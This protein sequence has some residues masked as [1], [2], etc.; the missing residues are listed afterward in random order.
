MPYR[1]L[2][3]TD[4][5]RF[6]ALNQAYQKGKELPPFK[7]AFSQSTFQKVISFLPTFEKM[8]SRQKEAFNNQIK[9][10]S[11]FHEQMKK[12]KLYISHFI[13]VVNMA[14]QRGEL[15]TSIREYYQLNQYGAKLPPLNTE[16]EVILLGNNMIEGEA[17]RIREGL[18]PI[19]N[20]TIAV[21]KVRYDNFIEAY[22]DKKNLQIT[23][24]KAFKDL[25]D[26]R[27]Q[28]DE[29]ILHVWN[30]VEESFKDLPDN[31][32]R[33]KAIE[34]GLVYVYRKN[35]KPDQDLFN[36]QRLGIS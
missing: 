22:N 17:S 6:K 16:D 24:N 4:S 28:A 27:P 11:E 20:P 13:Q 19:T 23:T 32:K 10:N 5:A 3:N 21:V 35:E 30:E 25:A 1:R 14:I 26:M 15:P 12:A 2:P 36:Q 29:I 7:L 34:Y 18:P 9:R 31:L 33:E 8:M